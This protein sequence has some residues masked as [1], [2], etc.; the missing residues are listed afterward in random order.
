M[1]HERGVLSLQPLYL[2]NNDSR[3]QNQGSY[4]GDYDA[5][6]NDGKSTDTGALWHRRRFFY[7]DTRPK[8]EGIGANCETL[9]EVPGFVLKSPSGNLQGVEQAWLYI[10]ANVDNHV[11]ERKLHFFDNKGKVATTFDEAA[12]EYPETNESSKL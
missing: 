1:S 9:I 10:S 2:A 12:E 5:D 3:D 11:V 6:V 8:S 7:D 4:S